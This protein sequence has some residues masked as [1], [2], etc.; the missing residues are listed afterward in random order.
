VPAKA[1]SLT[2][3]LK[4]CHWCAGDELY[5]AYHDQEWGVPMRDSKALFALLQLE[6]MQAGLSWITILKKRRHMNKAF[7]R[8]SPTQLVKKGPAQMSTW[9]NDAGLIRNR[10]KLAALISN[11]QAFIDYEKAEGRGAFVDLLWQHVKHRPL[12]NSFKTAAEVPADTPAS[13]AMSKQLKALG[14]RF[15]GPTICYAFM[16]SAGMVNDH[17]HGCFRRAECKALSRNLNPKE[18]LK[19]MKQNE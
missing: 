7:F 5:I 6:G 3:N 1:K 4:R 19:K 11:A 15:V 10:L 17:T 13:Q 9:L 12:Q 18:A 16:Q 14:F 8:F 2:K